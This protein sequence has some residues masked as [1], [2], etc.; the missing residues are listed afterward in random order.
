M[1]VS[2]Y[3]LENFFISNKKTLLGH[4][5]EKPSVGSILCANRD[6]LA[7]VILKS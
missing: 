4:M 1:A 5:Y 2:F 6:D 7:D 3:S